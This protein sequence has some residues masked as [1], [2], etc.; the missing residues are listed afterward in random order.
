[1]EVLPSLLSGEEMGQGRRW[2]QGGQFRRSRC[3]Q[4][5]HCNH[6]WGRKPWVWMS[7]GERN[8]DGQRR[9]LKFVPW[10]AHWSPHLLSTL[11]SGT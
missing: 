7:L 1:M 2:K 3:L 8:E 9:C 4:L 11:S 10:G 6:R 5:S